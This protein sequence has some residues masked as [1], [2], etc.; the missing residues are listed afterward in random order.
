MMIPGNY[1]AGNGSY[2]MVLYS[3]KV[4]NFF[5]ELYTKVHVSLSFFVTEQ[6][7]F[8]HLQV[9]NDRIGIVPVNLQN[10]CDIL[11]GSKTML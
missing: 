1:I 5:L 11:E 10:T 8:S 3:C 6:G 7:H 2:D 4:S 9:K